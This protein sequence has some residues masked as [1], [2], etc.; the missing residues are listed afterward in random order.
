MLGLLILILT[1]WFMVGLLGCFLDDHFEV[2]NVLM[3]I[4]LVSLPFIPWLAK[5]C[6]LV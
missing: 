1:L 3:L 5:W 4:F 6:G 2:V